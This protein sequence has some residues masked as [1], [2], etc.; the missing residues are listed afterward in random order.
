[1]SII[2]STILFL[3]ALPVATAQAAQQKNLNLT[4]GSSLS[5]SGNSSVLLS[6]SGIFA[7]GFFPFGDGYSISIWFEGTPQKTV[8]WTANRNDPPL[9]RNANIVFTSDGRL[10]LQKLG[11]QEKSIANATEPAVL[12]SI[13]C[14]TLA[15]LSSMIRI[16]QL[17]GKVLITQR[18]PFCLA[19]SYELGMSS[20]L[21]ALRPVG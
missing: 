6:Q 12:A 9:S 16:Q 17:Y 11:G 3:S 7:F 21:A 15:T 19:N 5:P 1:M 18:T 8:V 4:Q 13:P 14:S 20:F 2:A 10:I